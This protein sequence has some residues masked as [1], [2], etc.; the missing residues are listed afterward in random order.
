VIIVLRRSGPVSGPY[1]RETTI[2]SGGPLANAVTA[3]LV[4]TR[5]RRCAGSRGADCGGRRGGQH[6]RRGGDQTDDDSSAHGYLPRWRF[7]VAPA[8]CQRGEL[9]TGLPR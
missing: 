4:A 8:L 3:A 1:C 9:M 2:T 7:L 6:Q 5:T